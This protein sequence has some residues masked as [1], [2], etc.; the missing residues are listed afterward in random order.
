MV[1]QEKNTRKNNTWDEIGRG[2]SIRM[3]GEEGEGEGEIFRLELFIP[4]L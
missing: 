2:S 3:R 4:C 1:T